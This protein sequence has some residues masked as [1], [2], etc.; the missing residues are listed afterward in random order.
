MKYKEDGKQ[1][2]SNTLYSLLPETADTQFAKQ[3][4]EF[5]SEVKLFLVFSHIP[6]LF[7]F[8]QSM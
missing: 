1:K 4:S 6:L 3:Q 2:R 5:R 7:H 8:D